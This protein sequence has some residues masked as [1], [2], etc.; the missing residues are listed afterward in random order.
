MPCKQ[1]STFP[2]KWCHYVTVEADRHLKLLPACILE[3]QRVWAHWYAVHRRMVAALHGY[4]HPTYLRFWVIG[5]LWSQNDVIMSWL[6][7]IA[8]QTASRIHIRHI[9]SVWAHW[10]SA[11]GHTVAALYSYTHTSWLRW[12]GSGSLV[13]ITLSLHHGWGWQTPQTASHVHIKHIQNVWAHWYA[14]HGHTVAALHSH[15]H[16]I[17]IRLWGS[18]LLVE[19]K[20]CHYIMVEADSH[21]KL[22]SASLL[23]IY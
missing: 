2:Q 10:Y 8:P 12:W 11:H 18:G 14:V 23:D 9:Q 20:W 19:S 1:Q 5:N 22:R 21:L 7:L 3:I 6:M 13:V 16:T 15:T 17:E 4:T